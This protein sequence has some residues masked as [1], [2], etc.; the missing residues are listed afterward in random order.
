[1]EKMTIAGYARKTGK[2]R[3]TIHRWINKGYLKYEIQPSGT[4]LI[5]V[6]ENN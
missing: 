2:N 4:K 3:S 5:I 6:Q 1:M